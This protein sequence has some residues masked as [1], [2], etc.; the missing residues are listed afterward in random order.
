VEEMD[1]LKVYF[2]ATEDEVNNII[3]KEVYFG[4]ILGKHSEVCGTIEEGEI[5]KIEIDSETVDKVAKYLGCVWSG[6]SP[7][8]YVRYICPVCGDKVE[9]NE[10]SKENNKCYD[11]LDKE[12]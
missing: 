1:M 11:C 10:F 2:V 12:D 8:H 4:E 7:L 6:Y 5:T 3:G 9:A